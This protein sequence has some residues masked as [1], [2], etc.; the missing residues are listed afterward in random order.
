LLTGLQRSAEAILQRSQKFCESITQPTTLQ[1]NIRIRSLAIQPIALQNVIET[2]IPRPHFSAK[3][4]ARTA[5]LR[6]QG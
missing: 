4:N 6:V 5:P 1:Q 3:P 2:W